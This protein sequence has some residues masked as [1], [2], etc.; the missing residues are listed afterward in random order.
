MCYPPS[1]Y[2][3]TITHL[4]QH[5]RKACFSKGPSI[6]LYEYDEIHSKI[7]ELLDFIFFL[8]RL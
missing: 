4:T 8:C 5:S 3:M 6:P 7:P 1:N 2:V